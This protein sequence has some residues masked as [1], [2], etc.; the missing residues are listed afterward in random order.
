MGVVVYLFDDMKEI[1]KRQM[2]CRFGS[3][4]FY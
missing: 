3:G 4:P 1:E 2:I